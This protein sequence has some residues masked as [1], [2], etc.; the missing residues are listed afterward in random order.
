MSKGSTSPIIPTRYRSELSKG[1][2]YPFGAQSISAALLSV[3]QFSLLTISFHS[4]FRARKIGELAPLEFL[5][6]S[7]KQLPP[8]ISCSDEDKWGW[9]GPTWDISVRPIPGAQ[10]KGI[11]EYMERTGFSLVADWLRKSWEYHGRDGAARMSLILNQSDHE[12]SA[13]ASCDVLPKR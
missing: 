1:I 7:Y 5:R 12:V 9:R 6:I 2:S 10:R 13:Q 3:P 11:K 4:H 8:T